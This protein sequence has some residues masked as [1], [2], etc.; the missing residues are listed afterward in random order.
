MSTRAH[1]SVAGPHAGEVAARLAAR[2]TDLD[3]VVERTGA[4]LTIETPLD[5]P[6]PPAP[7]VFKTEAHDSAEFAAEKI[8]DALAAEGL[9]RLDG[10]SEVEEAEL[11]NR[12][13]RLGYIE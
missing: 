9:I 12:L 1:L 4:A 5:V 11:E 2:L 8:I 7:R 10:M 13:R 6:P 3:C